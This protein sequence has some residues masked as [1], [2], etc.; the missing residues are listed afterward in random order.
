M[1]KLLAYSV[2]DS[3]VQAFNRPFFQRSRGEALRGWEE[4]CN[5][6]DSAASKFPHDFALFEIGEFDDTN[7]KLTTYSTPENLGLAIQFKQ[8]P[9]APMPLFSKGSA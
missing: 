3:K 6:A 7:G 9:E 2:Y 5:Q 4:H 8:Q 1:A